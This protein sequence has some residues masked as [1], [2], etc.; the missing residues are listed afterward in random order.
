MI[1]LARAAD[2]DTPVHCADICEWRL[3]RRYSF[4]SAWDSIWHVPLTEQRELILKLLG[5]LEP[6][7]VLLFTAGGLDNPSEHTDSTMGPCL[8]YASLGIPELLKVVLEGGG[9]CRHLEFDQL[10]EKHLVIVTQKAL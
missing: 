3:P 8:Y 9:V 7:G 4:I 6:A 5:A 2:P 1:E 10:P